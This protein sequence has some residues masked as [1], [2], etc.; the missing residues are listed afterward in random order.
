[1]YA[2]RHAT[3]I[4]TPAH[5]MK[6]VAVII[7][8]Y[9]E[10]KHIANTLQSILSNDYESFEI[11]VV[12]D[13]ST[14]DTYKIA[15]AFESKHP[16]KVIRNITGKGTPAALNYGA[17]FTNSEYL[18]F[19]NADC[20]ASSD[21]IRNGTAAFDSD[22][23]VAVEGA[24]YYSNPKPSF[25]HRVPINPFY[26]LSLG[27]CLTVPGQDF[28]NGNFAIRKSVFEALG[29]FDTQ[30]FSRGRE[31]TDLGFRACKMGRIKYEPRMK[32]LHNEEFWTIKSLLKNAYRYDADVLFLKHHKTFFFLKGRIL[33][34]RFLLMLF[35]PPLILFSFRFK[36]FRELIFLPA[37]YLYLMWLRL[38]IWKTSIEESFYLI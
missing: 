16:V 19:I 31:D 2:N 7:P 12:D 28:A 10:E 26:N 36:S 11:I 4:T 15:K 8:A 1:M 23:V 30:V 22:E 33:H 32:V 18:F 25:R 9:N 13:S 29:G 38:R 37:F 14:D 24:M 3:Y 20:E 5:T 17:G 27:A 34:P 21:W 6:K 35:F